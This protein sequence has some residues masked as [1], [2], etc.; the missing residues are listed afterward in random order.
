MH[1]KGIL[2]CPG[3]V[4]TGSFADG[5]KTEGTLVWGAAKECI[6]MGGFQDDK[7]QGKG[8]IKS[9]A[10]HFDGHFV[11]GNRD[12]FGIHTLPD[13]SRYEG[14][15]KAD[16]KNGYGECFDKKGKLVYKGSWLNDYPIPESKKVPLKQTSMRSTK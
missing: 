12:G 11:K 10:G 9:P 5:H 8:T 16:M 13:G 15:F 6:Y 1:G 14:N 3:A 2:S 4:F 7:F